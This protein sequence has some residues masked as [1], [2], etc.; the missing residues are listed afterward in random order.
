MPYSSGMTEQKPY[1]P[2][3]PGFMGYA[4]FTLVAVIVIVFVIAF[5]HDLFTGQLPGSSDPCSQ[6]ETYEAAEFCADNL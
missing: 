3:K 6:Y 2:S 4:L 5:V 1:D